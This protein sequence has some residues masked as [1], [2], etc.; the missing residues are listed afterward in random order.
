[1]KRF[2]SLL[3]AMLLL[4]CPVVQATEAE[5][6]EITESYTVIKA[7]RN[8]LKGIYQFGV[9]EE[10]LLDSL[11]KSIFKEKDDNE[12]FEFVA[13]AI[14]DALDD[15]SVYFTSEE[16]A[17]FNEAVDAV[18][19]GIG[20]TL[21]NVDGYASVMNTLPNTP[22]E[23]SGLTAGDKIIAVDGESVINTDIDLV[24][25]RIRGEKGTDVVLTILTLS[26]E[27]KEIKITRDIV[28]IPSAECVINEKGDTAYVVITQFA[29]DTY[30]QFKQ[31]YDDF[32]SKGIN[33]LILDLR[34]N[35]GGYTSQAEKIASMFLPKDSVIYYENTR[36]YNSSIA[37]ASKN[38]NADTKT[39]IVVLTN[40]FTASASEILVGALKDNER[41][42]IIG[43]N[44]FGKGTMQN[45]ASMGEYGSVK[46]TF[47]EFFSPNKNAIN[48]VGI[49]PHKVVENEVRKAKES[50][51][52]PL[53]FKTKYFVGDENEEVK[54]IKER[55]A[56]MGLFTGDTTSPKYD[57][58]T[59]LAVMRFQEAYGL[60][61]YGVADINTQL[62]LH[63]QVMCSDIVVDTQL[64][65]AYKFLGTEMDK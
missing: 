56:I 40:E 33:N 12:A 49:A 39:K 23:S 42:T 28:V 47:A 27:T 2:L 31:I 62:T 17:E 53:S 60:Y 58:D 9:S 55:L 34:Y 46:V 64:K 52:K 24:S 38:E 63:T 65:E 61:P 1:M 32:K 22:A 16:M 50:D 6:T 26:G 13:D 11:I 14:T 54:A 35:S 48:E 8:Y 4:I 45:V 44:T 19:A 10:E 18:F 36:S 20:V 7:L 43:T 3:L 30:N 15:Y 21:V 5:E 41:A 51:V 57:T 29:E 37:F 59:E 25:S